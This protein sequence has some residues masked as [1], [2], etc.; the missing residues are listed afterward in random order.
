MNYYDINGNLAN[1]VYDIHGNIFYC[2]EPEN[3]DTIVLTDLVSYY[4]TPTQGLVDTL[5][6]TDDNTIAFVIVTDTHGTANKNN[7][8]NVIR[9]LLKNSK[10]NKCFWLGDVPYDQWESID[11]FNSYYEPLSNAN[12]QL[13]FTTGNHDNHYYS[14][15]TVRNDLVTICNNILV[16]KRNLTGN[17]EKFYYYFNDAIH[18]VRYIVINTAEDTDG[19]GSAIYVSDTQISWLKSA[20]QLPSSEWSI[21]VLSHVGINYSESNN[22]SQ[23]LAAKV[24]N[25]LNE[26]NGTIIGYFGGHM[27]IDK[28]TEVNG[29]KNVTLL[30]DSCKRSGGGVYD[31][32]RVAGTESEQAVS[33]VSINLSNKAV[34]IHRIGAGNDMTYSY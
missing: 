28:I 5:N 22:L 33:V 10:A 11:D 34:T 13:Y 19:T 12:S 1:I 29:I 8:Q 9:Y 4:Q 7:S 27:H 3:T 30:N 6:N 31:F 23:T 25:V 32:E 18:K 17:K 24:I 14:G 26:T 21:V 20:V 2:E 16:P 15:G